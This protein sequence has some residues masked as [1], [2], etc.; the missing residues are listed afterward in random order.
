MSLT[1]T[2]RGCQPHFL[3]HPCLYSPGPIIG[4]TRQLGWTKKAFLT[5]QQTWLCRKH[6]ASY[7]RYCK[8]RQ[9]DDG[10]SY[11]NMVSILHVFMTCEHLRYPRPST[12][13]TTVDKN[14]NTSQESA[15]LSRWTSDMHDLHTKC[16]PCA[17]QGMIS[18]KY[19]NI[20]FAPV[21]SSSPPSPNTCDRVFS[22]SGNARQSVLGL[23]DIL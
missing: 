18:N 22:Q 8:S 1:S 6:P 7:H 4:L 14:N 23:L 2:S 9:F 19:S 11:W 17:S 12:F 13:I 10:I 3:V 16:Q 5:Q 20:Y 15:R 21:Y